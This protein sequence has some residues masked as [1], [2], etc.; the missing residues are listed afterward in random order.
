MESA[1][2]IFDRDLIAR[3]QA[4]AARL[5]AETFL[6]DRVSDDVDDRLV[7]VLRAFPVALDLA[8]PGGRLAP[9]L[10]ARAGTT[11]AL[12]ANRAPA[13]PPAV[14]ADA[15]ALPFAEAS[16]DLVVSA[17]ALQLVNDLPGALAQARRALRPD[18]LFL[19]A[20][21]GGDTLTELRRSFAEAETELTGGVSPRV[22]PFADVRTLGALLQRAGFALP[23]T[24]LDRVT[25]RYATPFAL[26]HDLRRM[27]ATNPLVDRR[28]VPLRRDVL[29]RMAE[30]YTRR[31]GAADGR[32]PATF[33]IVWL[34]GW[35]PH[36][37]QP[38]PLRPGSATT[39]LADALRTTER[40]AGEKP[41]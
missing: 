14:A 19:A 17:L 8:T 34:T 11:F 30:T 41:G 7:A 26:M 24:D 13:A 3:R 40:S 23:V 31:F 25:V 36:A 22:A 32:V 18:G 33:D 16:L 2:T 15:E 21:L 28:R 27:G 5:G 38:K 10:A 37:S 29:L 39:R 12:A 35:A 1:P 4:R 6:L 9:R 20:L